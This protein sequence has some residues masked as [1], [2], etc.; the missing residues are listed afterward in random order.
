LVVGKLLRWNIGFGIKEVV[1]RLINK[2]FMKEEVSRIL[3]F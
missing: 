3:C 1:L 2:F